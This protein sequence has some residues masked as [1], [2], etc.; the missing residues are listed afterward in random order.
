ML[1]PVT[2]TIAH[3][4]GQ[5]HLSVEE[6]RVRQ[7]YEEFRHAKA[8]MEEL[9]R[10]E[11]EP[12]ES[13]TFKPDGYDP[14]IAWK[15]K[16]PAPPSPDPE[17][18]R[19]A[20]T[21]E[22]PAK[23][24][25][26]PAAPEPPE[27]AEAPPVPVEIP[28]AT[29]PQIVLA[30]PASVAT[31]TIQVAVLSDDDAFGDVDAAG[32][33]LPTDT[34]AGLDQLVEVAQSLSALSAPVLEGPSPWANMTE[35]LE[36][37]IAEVAE[38][39]LGP[40]PEGAAVVT[41]QGDA[42]TGLLV[43]GAIAEEMPEL[44]DHL[45]E[46]LREED[47]P[48]KEGPS[49]DDEAVDA[50]T[51]D[52]VVGLPTEATGE[53]VTGEQ[54]GE[55]AIPAPDEGEHLVEAGA[56][57][58]VNECEI[59]TA[60][61]DAK[62]IAVQ[63]D[64]TQIVA[65]NQVNVLVD[66]PTPADAAEAAST[67]LNAA[68]VERTSSAAEEPEGPPAAEVTP[69]NWVVTRIEGDLVVFNWVRQTTYVTDNDRAVVTEVGSETFVGLGGNEVSNLVGIAELGANYDL[70]VVGGHMYDITVLTQWNIL[71]DDDAL[72]GGDA[73]GGDNLLFNSASL[74]VEGIDSYG[75]LTADYADV[76]Q[77]VVEG[78]ATMPEFLAS[79]GAVLAV[80]LVRVV[81]VTGDLVKL[82]AI[83]QS[84]ILADCDQIAVVL[85]EAQ[86]QGAQVEVVAGSNALANQ[87]TIT[88]LG[89]DSV[90]MAGGTIY[91]DA[92]IHQAGLV[93]DEAP[94][95]GVGLAP[96][97]AGGLTPGAVAFLADDMMGNGKAHGR[98]DGN[99]LAKG[100]AGRDDLG[101]PGHGNGN[102]HGHGGDL[103]V[104]GG[105]LS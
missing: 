102:A 104:L 44:A 59:T 15:A 75:A 91:T 17:G 65:I 28:T 45:P 68:L 51:S 97:P 80:E 41:V 48:A 100:H 77:A 35:A 40:V 27:V 87:V 14:G 46:H 66:A 1:D 73:Q 88:E 98:G 79:E 96:G 6:M 36:S 8:K 11:H 56:N 2:E 69:S 43:N 33:D 38:G 22:A 90:V 39:A 71:L 99:G 63:G 55:G 53:T 9:A 47:P 49:P 18:P 26:A 81:Y 24:V 52:G 78:T 105:V 10:K 89:I 57:L 54:T 32:F 67:L 72:G 70:I 29:S 4:V 76:V 74:E 103:D 7:G 83:E 93:A 50:P 92:L 30:P 12:A 84:N 58:L 37:Q 21:P 86:A 42:A 82:T 16:P 19:E 20:A 5:L 61:I 85:D 3:F 94:P 64:V 62:V 13:S 31:V 101:G 95:A 23:A 60:W 25:T 34:S